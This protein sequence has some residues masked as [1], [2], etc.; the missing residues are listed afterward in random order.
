MREWS[1]STAWNVNSDTGAEWGFVVTQSRW[2]PKWPSNNTVCGHWTRPH[3]GLMADGY[4]AP[5]PFIPLVKVST[6][7]LVTCP[8][9]GHSFLSLTLSPT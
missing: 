1:E 2:T 3:H 8:V 7:C 9:G 4:L 5:T 6:K